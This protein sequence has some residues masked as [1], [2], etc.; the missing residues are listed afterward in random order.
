MASGRLGNKLLSTSANTVIY[1]VPAGKFAVV[2]VSALN[3]TTTNARLTIALSANATPI[4]MDQIEL[5]TLVAAKGVFERS[6][7]A[8]KSGDKVICSSPTANAFAI[9]VH[10][11]EQDN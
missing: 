3:R 7:L 8:I 10:G 6:G 9:V 1:T 4:A 5:E 11:I 2:T